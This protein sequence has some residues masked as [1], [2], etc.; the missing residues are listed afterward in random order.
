MLKVLN[1]GLKFAILPLK[2][3]ISQVLTDY[4]RFERT[5]VWTE[6]WFGRE[7]EEYIQ[8]I[9]KQK[10]H[11]FPI[12]HNTPR[13]LQ[14]YLAAV[15]SDL[16]DPLNRNKVASNISI[17]EKEALKTL[18][19]LQKERQI[20]VKPCDKGAGIIV[21]DFQ[22]YLRACMEHLEAET[23]TGDPY[24]RLV[25]ESVLEEAK[26]KI[27]KIV[28][29]GFDNDI[30][31]KDEYNAMLPANNA[32]PGRFYGTFKVHKKYKHGR[33]PP[34]RGIVSCSGT[35]MENIRIYVEHNLKEI[36]K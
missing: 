6:F 34:F 1:R 10:K 3:D 9:F 16:V 21:L 32:V 13:G 25:N 31:T 12:K 24:Y 33:A 30:L 35:F 26:E 20:V 11:N 5:M 27:T 23:A 28:K 8:P 14:N 7:T 15:K 18:M 2:L 36:G 17:E 4:R 22:E 29:K 19:K